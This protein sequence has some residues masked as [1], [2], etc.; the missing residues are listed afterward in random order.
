M[1]IDYPDPSLKPSRQRRIASPLR[2]IRLPPPRTLPTS[3]TSPPV[4]TTSQGEQQQA[5]WDPRS[6]V[7]SGAPTRSKDGEIV[8]PVLGIQKADPQAYSRGVRA[9]R[10]E[11]KLPKM[12][13]IH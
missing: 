12:D 4:R 3:P 5:P 13:G 2:R 9:A 6:G 11:Q 1:E 10:G 7:I 8:S